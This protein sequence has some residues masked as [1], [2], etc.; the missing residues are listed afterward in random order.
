MSRRTCNVGE[1]ASITS[2]FEDT[3]C[4]LLSC[5]PGTEPSSFGACAPCPPGR[6]REV[7]L[8]FRDKLE[9]V[10]LGFDVRSNRPMFSS[11]RGKVG[12]LSVNIGASDVSNASN[13]TTPLSPAYENVYMFDE[14][15]SSGSS[16]GGTGT[17]RVFSARIAVG[18]MSENGVFS[19]DPGRFVDVAFFNAALPLRCM[20]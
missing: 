2:N 20:K 5:P 6:R 12:Y 16:D 18:W 13:Q 19:A 17:G 7:D 14:A 8:L 10:V 3:D 4:V 15:K 11:L 9:E 1:T